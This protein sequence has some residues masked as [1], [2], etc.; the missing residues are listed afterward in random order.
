MRPE[1][2]DQLAGEKNLMAA[3]AYYAESKAVTSNANPVAPSGGVC[4][5]VCT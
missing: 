3:E 4:L 2:L 1:E 5:F